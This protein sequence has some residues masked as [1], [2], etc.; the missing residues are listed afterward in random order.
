MNRVLIF[1][2]FAFIWVTCFGLVLSRALDW[3]LLPW[4]G[5][6][7]A[8]IRCRFDRR[9][10]RIGE[11]V[12]W[13][14]WRYRDNGLTSVHFYG[15]PWPAGDVSSGH[16]NPFSCLRDGS[17]SL[18]N[19]SGLYCFKRRSEA[20]EFAKFL[21]GYERHKGPAVFGSVVLWGEI[22]E[23]E[24]GYRAQFARVRSIERIYPRNNTLLRVLQSYY[25]PEKG[26]GNV[27]S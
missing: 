24:A 11:V 25:C 1:S 5:R 3:I 6:R 18:D 16:L 10:V 15:R 26:H 23:H 8:R 13:R 17:P 9:E 21:A 19:K 7:V 14:V 27:P 20:Q 12:G 4:L 2:T 22:V